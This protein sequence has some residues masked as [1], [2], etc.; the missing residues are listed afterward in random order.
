LPD[1]PVSDPGVPGEDDVP[2]ID[3]LSGVPLPIP[4]GADEF[5]G[6]IVD[7][8][9]HDYEM[10]LPV[11]VLE[12]DTSTSKGQAAAFAA[13]TVLVAAVG[14]GV[15][16]ANNGDQSTGPEAVTS[17]SVETSTTA[18]PTT[19]DAASV[20]PSGTLVLGERLIIYAKNTIGQR[21]WNTGFD[22]YLAASL[23]LD[24]PDDE[25]PEYR[26]ESGRILFTDVDQE[27]VGTG[28]VY[29]G[30]ASFV[31]VS[32]TDLL[33]QGN[34]GVL[35][36]DL[37]ADPPTYSAQ[38]LVR[39]LDRQI[40]F[41]CPETTG[42]TNYGDSLWWVD[43][44]RSEDPYLKTDSDDGE[45]IFDGFANGDAGYTDVVWII[46]PC[47]PDLCDSYLDVLSDEKMAEII[48][49]T[50]VDAIAEGP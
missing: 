43:T 29:R 12:Q 41:T 31:A 49:Q 42:E 23:V 46:F 16:A 19:A 50:I 11:D 45:V 47:Q 30:G 39:D 6:E 7:R 10:G 15:W 3:P 5:V 20:D 24:D 28:C 37:T 32:A 25:H 18:P 22:S 4:E 36:F 9:I 27:A 17:T 14:V 21:S 34:A 13:A 2:Q 8:R 40:T 1:Q 38:F 35:R 26:F 44:S 33:V 48:D